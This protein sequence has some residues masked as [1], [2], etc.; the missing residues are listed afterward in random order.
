MHNRAAVVQQQA[1]KRILEALKQD[2][3]CLANE[4][5]MRLELRGAYQ[6]FVGRQVLPNLVKQRQ[7]IPHSFQLPGAAEPSTYYSNPTIADTDRQKIATT[8]IQAYN[9]IIKIFS[10]RSHVGD[11]FEAI[12]YIALVAIKQSYP[13]LQLSLL[14]PRDQIDK[15]DEQS[16][17]FDDY[18]TLRIGNYGVQVKNTMQM[19]TPTSID[20]RDFLQVA[21]SRVVRP[22]LVNRISSKELKATMLSYR[23]RVVDSKTA[24]VCTKGNAE[25][26]ADPFNLLG[27]HGIIQELPELIRLRNEELNGTEFF[28]S[29]HYDTFTFEEL[30]NSASNNV[31]PRLMSKM[32]GLF[33]CLSA[34]WFVDI[35]SMQLEHKAE[36][37]IGAILA[38]QAIDY[39]LRSDGQRVPISALVAHGESK[40]RPPFSFHKA[41][42]T[43]TDLA[44][45]LLTRLQALEEMGFVKEEAS[46][47]FA[48]QQGLSHPEEWLKAA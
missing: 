46:Q 24:Y 14:R 41:R 20:I 6:D 38:T 43:P 33:A 31:P 7:I 35:A 48:I 10:T 2:G 4:L 36:A 8:K 42:M 19:F 11:F 1:T 22:I 9:Q 45:L 39:L 17:P 30:A 21:T 40:I 3:V 27:I 44:A 15:I 18:I 29:R 23:G 16:Y 28:Q 34:S 13:S 25:F 26:S 5:K 47:E 32:K 37:M 12:T